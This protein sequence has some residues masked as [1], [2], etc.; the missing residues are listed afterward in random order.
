MATA[1]GRV[2][3][4]PRQVQRIVVRNSVL[5]R[6]TAP[7]NVRRTGVFVPS[8]VT[9]FNQRRAQSGMQTGPRF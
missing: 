7:P 8:R 1:A 6:R 9:P 3:G 4:S 5:R 2:L